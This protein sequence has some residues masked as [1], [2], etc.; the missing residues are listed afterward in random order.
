MTVLKLQAVSWTLSEAKSSYQDERIEAT[1]NGGE[2]DTYAIEV[3]PGKKATVSVVVSSVSSRNIG[4]RSIFLKWNDGSRQ[5]LPGEGASDS[6]SFTANGSVTVGVSCSAGTHEVPH[7]RVTYIGGKPIYSIYYTTEYWTYYQCAVIYSVSVSYESLLPDLTVSAFSLSSSEVPVGESAIMSYGVKNV[8]GKPAAETT[9]HIYDGDMRIGTA[10]IGAL[11]VGEEL[12]RTFTIKNFSV[13]RHVL[14]VVADATDSIDEGSESNNQKTATF[15]VYE[16]KPYTVYFD[17]NGGTGTTSSQSF[18]SGVAQS[19]SKNTFSNGDY[20]FMGWA[21]SADGEVEYVDEEEVRAISKT[22]GTVTLYAVWRKIWQIEDGV[23]VRA[24]TGAMRSVT[25]PEGVTSIGEGA[26]AFCENLASIKLPSTLTRIGDSAFWACENLTCV[27]IPEGVRYIGKNAFSHCWSLPEVRIPSTVE[28]IGNGAF[29]YNCFLLRRV[30]FEGDAPQLHALVSA[31]DYNDKAYLFRYHSSSTRRGVHTDCVVYVKRGSSGWGASIPGTW[32]DGV[33][34]RYY[35]FTVKFDPNGGSIT[36]GETYLV[37]GAKLVGAERAGEIR[38]VANGEAVGDLPTAILPGYA[39]AGWFTDAD[40]T[41]ITETTPI[42]ENVVCYARWTSAGVRGDG[43]GTGS[44]SMPWTATKATVLNGVV[45]DASGAIVGTVELK[46]GKPNNRNRNTKVSGSMTRLNGMKTVFRS[47]TV[48]VP[49]NE[50]LTASLSARG[51]DSLSVSIGDD[52][53]NGQIGDYSVVIASVGG[54]WT[55][56][57]ATVSI[58]LRDGDLPDGT[59]KEL[60]PDGDGAEPVIQ[61]VGKWKFAKAASVKW[62]KPKKGAA[63]SEYYDEASGK[64]LVVDTSAGKTNLSAMKLTYTPKKGTFKGS[65]KVYALEG[66]GKA[67]KLKKYTVKVSGV[68]VGG[69]GYGTAT[70]KSPAVSWSV[71]VK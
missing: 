49:D 39:F 32:V 56:D 9:V 23:L 4:G 42:T 55:H 7:T 67:R 26:F 41:Q 34:I 21:T 24:D 36:G 54:N 38:P 47:V 13:G 14:K 51:L 57:G 35:D 22:G 59:L 60:L 65:F 11:D 27:N 37:D 46:V 8:G 50:P 68:V 19:L 40:T 43:I 12:S 69:V 5:T 66:E 1:Q 29:A 25:V 16:R 18:V 48:A 31:S 10:T 33:A 70:C 64:D 3:P 6:R 2:S 62:A 17:P 30:I 15:V 45:Y 52:G 20:T 44:A 63:R 28:D 71:T 61:K 53:F 58:E